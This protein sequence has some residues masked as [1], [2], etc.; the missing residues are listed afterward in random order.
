M[1]PTAMTS[2]ESCSGDTLATR[3]ESGPVVAVRVWALVHDSFQMA[4]LRSSVNSAPLA[5]VMTWGVVIEKVMTKI[6]AI[7]SSV[8]IC[9]C[10]GVGDD[11]GWGAVLKV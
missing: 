10:P 1:N 7:S 5:E 6:E 3:P 4:V 2:R 9:C 11:T 8:T